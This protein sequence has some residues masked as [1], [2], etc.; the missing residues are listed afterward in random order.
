MDKIRTI[1]VIG[2]VTPAQYKEARL[3]VIKSGYKP[4]IIR[5]TPEVFFDHERSNGRIKAKLKF[6]HKTGRDINIGDDELELQCTY[7]A[8]TLAGQFGRGFVA[9]VMDEDVWTKFWDKE[10]FYSYLLEAFEYLNGGFIRWI[11][12]PDGRC[13]FAGR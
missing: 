8:R 11:A 2:S 9:V 7:E 6:N 4:K 3:D 12:Y 5:T 1:L 13:E 10:L